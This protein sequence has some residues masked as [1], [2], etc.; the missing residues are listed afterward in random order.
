M[1]A[2]SACEDAL[3][4]RARRLD[5]GRTGGL[6]VWHDDCSRE[7]LAPCAATTA[8]H[9][10]RRRADARASRRDGVSVNGVRMRASEIV[11]FDESIADRAAGSRGPR[12]PRATV[13]ACERDRG[14]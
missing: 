2:G 13:V 3:A 10:A 11:D 7:D 14:L 1:P 6:Q 12:V 4:I 8:A 5:R 9:A